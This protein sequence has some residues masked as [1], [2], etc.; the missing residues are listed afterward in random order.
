MDGTGE[1]VEVIE[2]A[3]LL[4]VDEN[5]S[6]LFY[7]KVRDPTNL[8]EAVPNIRDPSK[9]AF[10]VMRADLDGTNQEFVRTL[11]TPVSDNRVYWAEEKA[12]NYV[13]LGCH[14]FSEKDVK[15]YEVDGFRS[16]RPWPVSFLAVSLQPYL[17]P[18]SRPLCS[19][20]C[21]P[22]PAKAKFQCLCPFGF[23]LNNDGHTCSSGGGENLFLFKALQC[24]S[25]SI[26]LD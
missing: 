12:G 21:V 22:T 3:E 11:E 4:A 20:M 17:H 23:A 9:Y 5:S 26:G 6:L 19:H 10:D 16:H 8:T 13:I 15:E 25:I 14:K 7:I 2:Q 18:G 24:F 1:L